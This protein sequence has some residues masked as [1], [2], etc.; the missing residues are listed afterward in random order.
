MANITYDGQSFIVDSKRIWL[1]SGSVHYARIP[2]QLWADRIRAAKEAGL[3]CVETYVFWNFHESEP[4][5]FR[6]EGDANLRAFVEL[7][8]AAGMYCILR[9]GP[10]ICGEWDFGGLPA[11]LHEQSG[12]RVREGNPLFLQACARYIDAIMGQV[13]DLQATEGGPIILVQNENEWFSNNDEQA[14]D[15]LQEINRFLRESGCAVPIINCNNLWQPVPGTIDCWNG[16]DDL[17]GVC[18]Q[19][20]IAQPEAPRMVIEL[21]TGG[22]DTW[23]AEHH[24]HKSGPAIFRKLC[25]VASAGAMANLFM[26]HG[27]TNFGFWGGRTSGGPD[28]FITNSNDH[29]APLTEA[30]GRG[31]K[32]AMLRRV[33]MFL[34]QFGTLMAHLKPEA[35][36]TISLTGPAVIQQTGAQGDVVF[37]FQDEQKPRKSVE[38]MTPD[39]QTLTVN[40]GDEPAAWVTLNANLDGTGVLDLTNLRPWAF[41]NRKLLV[42]YGP[43]GSDGVVSVS[44]TVM[45]I[46]VPTS[47][48]PSVTHHENMTIA[49]LSDRQI[50]AA[51]HDGTNLY[52]GVL[53]FDADG[54]P[55]PHPDHTSSFYIVKPGE[56]VS[57]KKHPTHDGPPRAPK[58]ADWQAS[59]VE[60]YISGQAPRYATLEGPRSLERCGVDYGYGWYKVQVRKPRAGK[61]NLWAPQGNDRL[62]LYQ[63]GKLLKVLG[64]GP[65]AT[66]DPIEV[67]LPGGESE[68]ILMAD[69]L[70]RYNFGPALGENKGLFG[71]LL[72]VHPMKLKKAEHKLEPC[73][74]PFE[75]RGYVSNFHEGDRTP[76]NRYTWTIPLKR[77]APLVI[78]AKGARPRT[79]LFINDKAVTIDGAEGTDFRYVLD[80]E[81]TKKGNNTLSIALLDTVGD[82]FDPRQVMTV[83][84]VREV[85]SAKTKW[86]F[87]RWNLPQAADWD[88]KSTSGGAHQPCWYRTHFK[89][90][91]TAAPL[92]LSMDGPTKGQIYLNGRNV[93]RYFTATSSGKPVGPQSL[94]YLPEPWLNVGGDNELII[95]E[96]H[97][98]SPAKCKLVYDENAPYGP[99]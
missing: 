53:G 87:A 22:I 75:L 98:R 47:G 46:Q 64:H 49:V 79:V 97:G 77:K 39:G 12:L 6:F 26:F 36:H 16:W 92:W 68:L 21:R 63:K 48:A 43:A 73:V 58:L 81:L 76:R 18:R 41:L 27:G 86:W 7:V 30:G 89:V 90:A 5:R 37:V 20:R 8:K 88:P 10:F 44:G 96:E 65:G 33:S 74:D 61:V 31:P 19:I 45:S 4:G 32:Y 3:N 15:Y 93:G 66:D 1:M 56:E 59:G 42:L 28:R 94:Y 95:F 82:D 70:G 13:K 91:S 71:H 25:E 80:E 38:I 52:V 50:D 9:P 51:Y 99:R 34:S 2:H 67:T 85:L 11:W 17:L 78:R 60:A 57:R 69:N 84:Q 62:H 83:F 24:N 23:G 14:A 40:M 35:N 55:L 54:R 29:D 72:D